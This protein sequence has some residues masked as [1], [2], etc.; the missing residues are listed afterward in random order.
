MH[1]RLG[2]GRLWGSE[3]TR[4]P[5]EQT[6]D[7][8][9]APHVRLDRGRLLVVGERKQRTRHEQTSW[10]N[11]KHDMR[12]G[13]RARPAGGILRERM[14]QTRDDLAEPR[15]RRVRNTRRASV[16]RDV[17]EGSRRD[18]ARRGEGA[19]ATKRGHT[20]VN[21]ETDK[22]KNAKTRLF[23]APLLGRG[24]TTRRVQWTMARGS[25]RLGYVRTSM[26]GRRRVDGGGGARRKQ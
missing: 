16:D 3:S 11:R 15:G 5:D 24:T 7:N 20:V 17:L 8:L 4:L 2:R 22:V 12:W 10:Q 26:T 25:A 9:A 21:V 13:V 18:G 23:F 14:Q 1:L 6:R 19:T